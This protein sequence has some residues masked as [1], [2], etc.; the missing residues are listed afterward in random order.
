M[1]ARRRLPPLASLALVLP[2]L[3]SCQLLGGGSS[4]DDALEVV[5]GDATR[6]TFVDRAATAERLGVDGVGAD[7]D[8]AELAE[9]VEVAT[10]DA[11]GGT[12]LAPFTVAM[13]DAALS[14]L[15]VRWWVAAVVDGGPPVDVYKVEDVDLDDLVGD[16]EDV[17]FDGE[18]EGGRT[19][20]TVASPAGLTG[21]DGGLIDGRYPVQFGF[22]VLVDPDE[23]LVAVGVG[24]DRVVD[25]LDDEEDSLV[26]TDVF[27][28]VTDGAGDVELAHLAADPTCGG[29]HGD[30]EATEASGVG[31]LGTPEAL[32]YFVSGDGDDVTTSGRLAFGDDD[33]AESDLE[34]REAFLADGRSLR[35]AQPISDLGSAELEQDGSVV[36]MEIDLESP[37]A[38]RRMALDGDAFFACAS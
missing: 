21:A 18:E 32:G 5:P 36:T 29:G 4:L 24:L 25:V 22:G 20:L 17:G 33:A 12:P 2:A 38:G 31:R 8:E 11:V 3:T 35:T 7:A 30:A 28:D 1:T 6:V 26:D 13:Q 34:A 14:D 9:Y 16:L 37:R 19:L 27:D 15:D 23:D 10:Q